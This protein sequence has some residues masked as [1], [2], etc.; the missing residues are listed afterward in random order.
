[1][2]TRQYA[3]LVSDW[4]AGARPAPVLSIVVSTFNERAS[5]PILV[6][7]CLRNR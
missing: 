2:T 1:M 3:R 6:A 5:V 4:I 7:N